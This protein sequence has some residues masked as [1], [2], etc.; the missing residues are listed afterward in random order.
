MA[1]SPADF[2]PSGCGACGAF[3]A[4]SQ[5]A[6]CK[7]VRYCNGECQ[8]AAWSAGH[9]KECSRLKKAGA[10]GMYVKTLKEAPEGAESPAPGTKVLVHYTGTLANGSKFDSSRD[11][12]TP[13]SFAVG[14]GRVIRGWDEGVAAMKYG[15]RAM[16]YLSPEYGYGDQGAGGAIPGNS[17]LI[18]DVELI[19]E[20]K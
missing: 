8:T 20:D 14:M 3:G 11:R 10:N 6:G 7:A 1:D 13:F 19:E 17:F 18:F 5:C 9:K 16:F 4:S 2:P 15:Q 12:G